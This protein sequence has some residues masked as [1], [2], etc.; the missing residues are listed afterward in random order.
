M[1]IESNKIGQT[2]CTNTII[3]IWPGCIIYTSASCAIVASVK[4]GITD[5][6]ISADKWSTSVQ[7]YSSLLARY[8]AP[9]LGSESMSPSVASK[10]IVSMYAHSLCCSSLTASLQSSKSGHLQDVCLCS[11]RRGSLFSIANCNNKETGAI[12]GCIVSVRV[13]RLEQ[14]S[15]TGS[16]QVSLRQQR[17]GR[18]LNP[19]VGE[20]LRCM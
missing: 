1:A 5:N 14:A 4:T 3:S 11:V 6:E 17:M 19:T 15:V 18:L 7:N 9:S 10:R 20:L 13:L 12:C 2:R 16:Y 8:V